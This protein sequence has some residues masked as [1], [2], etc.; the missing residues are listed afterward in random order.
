MISTV[1][2]DIGETLID[3]T[4]IWARWADRL[5][6]PRLT[7]MG[8][9]G[10]IAAQGRSHMEIFEFFRPGFDLR[11]ELDRW[12]T[13]DPDGLRENFDVDDLYQDVRPTFIRLREMG[14]RL[15]I[16]GNQPR[17]AR[18]ALKAMGLGADAVLI[19]ADLGFEKPSREFFRKVTEMAGGNAEQVLY[20]GDRL[21]NDVLPA[22]SAGMKAVLIRRGPWGFL[23]AE[24]AE[25]AQADAIIDGLAEIPGLLG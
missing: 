10:G 4:R 18:E 3:E 6:V 20:V 23:Q 7:L 21:D 22:K 16:A 15:V 13:D 17:H 24:W 25:A 2:F 11:T 8:V 14:M 5:G 19:S 1:A 9:L 12:R